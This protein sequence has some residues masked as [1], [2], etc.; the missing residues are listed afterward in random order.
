MRSIERRGLRL[1]Q[2]GGKASGLVNRVFAFSVLAIPISREYLRLPGR[3]GM[4]IITSYF[5]PL[6]F[7]Q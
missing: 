4:L 6:N 2:F 5:L 7:F 3:L 1:A